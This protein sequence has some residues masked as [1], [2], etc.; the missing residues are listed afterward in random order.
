MQNFRKEIAISETKVALKQILFSQ[1]EPKITILVLSN[2]I[3]RKM[4]NYQSSFVY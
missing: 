4:I 2:Q 1:A 3:A